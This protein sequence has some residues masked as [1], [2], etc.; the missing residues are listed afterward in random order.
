MNVFFILRLLLWTSACSL[1]VR[2]ICRLSLT[3]LVTDPQNSL[4]SIMADI[5][6]GNETQLV[7]IEEHGGQRGP[8]YI[9][10]AD[11]SILG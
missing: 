7:D 8:I 5:S 10:G 9:S 1:P 6:V 2:V 11:H 4:K 3:G